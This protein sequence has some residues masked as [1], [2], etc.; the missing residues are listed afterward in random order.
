METID[1]TLYDYVTERAGGGGLG[2]PKRKLTIR[3]PKVDHHA[4][5]LEGTFDLLIELAKG[6]NGAEVEVK[7]MADEYTYSMHSHNTALR[8]IPVYDPNWLDD[9]YEKIS[10]SDQ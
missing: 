10:E 7:D 4:E 5:P 6:I 1:I 8:K 3:M 2:H 9:K